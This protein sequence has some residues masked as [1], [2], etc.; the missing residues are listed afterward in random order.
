MEAETF[1]Y[2]GNQILIAD[3]HYFLFGQDSDPV[4]TDC[5]AA[6]EHGRFTINDGTAGTAGVY[7]CD[8]AGATTGWILIHDLST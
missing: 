3:G 5:D 7:V 2:D 1:R 6:G 4:G 8:Q